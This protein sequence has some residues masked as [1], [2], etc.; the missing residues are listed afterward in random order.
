M[1]MS[2]TR[3]HHGSAKTWSRRICKVLALLWASRKREAA[4]SSVSKQTCNKTTETSSF[5]SV[6]LRHT[7][8]D[9]RESRVIGHNPHPHPF[10]S[11]LVS[12]Q[13]V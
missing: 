5:V 12:V 9:N 2:R 7:R 4:T 6:L 11:L 1:G 3:A 13:G 10:G 8:K